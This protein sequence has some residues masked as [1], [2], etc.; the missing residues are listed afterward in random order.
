LRTRTRGR[1]L[2][3]VQ[4]KVRR[5]IA[6]G[7]DESCDL[8]EGYAGL[9][10]MVEFRLVGSLQPHEQAAL[11]PGLGAKA[12]RA[13]LAD[14]KQRG[15]QAPLEITDAGVV[16]DGHLR[17]RAALELGWEKVEVRVV[18]PPD[19]VEYL[20]LAA[21][22]RRQLSQS[23]KAA[24]AVELDQY[25]QLQDE[26]RERRLANLKGQPAAD[27]ATLPVRG[28]SRE[29]AARLA[30]VS[31]RTI[32]YAATVQAADPELFAK[33]KDGRLP[34]VEAAR[35]VRQRR[36]DTE[37][38]EAPAPLPAGCWDVLL[39]DPPWPMPGRRGSGR[40]VVNHYPTMEIE[41]I[42]AFELPVAND[43]L[44][45]LWAVNSML[46]QALEILSVWGFEFQTQFVW[47]KDQIGLGHWNRT[48][49]ELLLLGRRGS[50]PVPPPARRSSSVLAGKRGAHS[51][52]PESAH[53]LIERMVPDG[54]KLE[55]FRRGP[56]RP[57]WDSWGNQA[58]PAQAAT[59]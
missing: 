12:Y 25:R 30:G 48:Q 1:C 44:L 20:L 11:L 36:R 5:P 31:A 8:P 13:F 40:S 54:R 53:E 49:H 28:R 4:K 26:G 29:R 35:Q 46:P 50:F 9:A 24:L 41:Q 51:A 42:A 14:L 19:E 6:D 45:F 27:V 18:S 52:K 43:A 59:G 47:V 55:L 21:L 16:L 34:A 32:Q 56:A 17:L 2:G 7:M 58:E 57:G 22:Q 15:L 37:L 3:C 33:V 39:A 10:G 38:A 23:Q